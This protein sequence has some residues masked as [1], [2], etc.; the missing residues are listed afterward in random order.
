V[1][2]Y[3]NGRINAFDAFTGASLGQLTD[4]DGEPIQID[5][6]RALKL[7]NG[8]AGGAA[9][10][11]YFTAAPFDGSHGLFGSLI[12]VASGS[13]EGLA[14]AQW[15]QANLDAVQLDAQRLVK[16]LSSGVP[17]GTIWRDIETLDADSHRLARAEQGS[18]QD[19]AADQTP[20]TAA[21]ASKAGG[22]TRGA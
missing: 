19:T 8:G 4:P 3:G 14:E 9:D 13:P 1:G 20:I 16:D 17:A 7:G 6:L 12:A 11:V 5:G 18:I 15:V 2:N 22:N 21:V 10:T